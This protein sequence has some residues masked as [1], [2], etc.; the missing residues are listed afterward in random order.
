MKI[1]FNLEKD[2]KHCIETKIK[3][4]YNYKV[5]E[6]LK[7]GKSTN[8]D[9]DEVELL[10]YALINFNFSALRLKCK[11]NTIKTDNKVLI[12]RNNNNITITINDVQILQE[13]ITS[14]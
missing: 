5:K 2:D 14:G 11:A 9:S 13:Y 12:A 4:I 1:Y 7:K 8:T 10:K 3:A 6:L